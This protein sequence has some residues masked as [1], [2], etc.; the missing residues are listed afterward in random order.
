M[1]VQHQKDL[2][3]IAQILE[4][5]SKHMPRITSL[6]DLVVVSDRIQKAL[7]G[8]YR[9]L[10]QF[11]FQAI[12]YLKR[13]PIR[14]VF[15]ITWPCSRKPKFKDQF[16]SVS[17]SIREHT[18]WIDVEVSVGLHIKTHELTVH[19]RD[20]ILSRISL[21]ASPQTLP[22]PAAV[23]H[24][25]IPYVANPQFFSRTAELSRLSSLLIPNQA[26]LLIISIIGEGGIGKTQLALQFAYKHFADYTAI[27]WARADS[28]LSLAQSYENIAL[29]I[30]LTQ[31][32]RGSGSLDITR[33]HHSWLLVFDN[34]KSMDHLENY[35]PAG[36]HGSIIL[37]TRD[38][39]LTQP[40]ISNALR[41][42]CF[43]EEEG[44]QFI[45]EHFPSRPESSADRT[46]HARE[47][48][49]S[50]GG[51][52]LALSQVIRYASALHMPIGEVRTICSSPASFL[53]PN[54]ELS[55]LNRTDFY[56]PVGTSALW[57]QTIQSLGPACSTLA[58][59]LA[60]LNPDAIPG[61]LLGIK[62]SPRF[63]AQF[64]PAVAYV[65]DFKANLL[66]LL[67]HSLLSGGTAT[68][69]YKMHRL[70][71]AAI[72]RELTPE[73]TADAFALA[74]EIINAAF[75]EY[76]DNDRLVDSWQRCTEILP[77]VVRLSD[78]FSSSSPYTLHTYLQLGQLLER[79]AYYL[80][81]RS[82]WGDCGPL[83]E[84]ASTVTQ[85]GLQKA[86]SRVPPTDAGLIREFIKLVSDIENT[87]AKTKMQSGNFDQAL[88]L[89]LS[90]VTTRSTLNE[91]DNELIYIR[92]NVVYA[93]LCLG[94]PQEAIVMLAELGDLA[95]QQFAADRN[96][97]VYR[98][99]HAN[100]QGLLCFA[101]LI[102]GQFG[103]A[104][105]AAENCYQALSE[106]RKCQNDLDEAE[107]LILKA[108][109]M[110]TTA[111]G[112]SAET[113][114]TLHAYATVLKEKGAEE[115]Q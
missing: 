111:D 74:L 91:L 36:S 67:S 38:Q 89:Y 15:K 47:I 53:D 45:L 44:I 82:S 49:K 99:N 95:D 63:Q 23:Q 78:I 110:R 4:F 73:Q 70:I 7:C 106:I 20:E 108:L 8:L 102:L 93:Y 71:Q 56:H 100:T 34:V 58:R 29:E 21:L 24:R 98:N 75:P 103:E 96:L 35:W 46:E 16:A 2:E 105:A 41:L 31:S 97:L 79:A 39:R 28:T 83:L 115:A 13:N 88:Q 81:E 109:D 72:L 10:I 19:G 107:T 68:H 50:C 17:K 69:D 43:S 54:S 37:T 66:Q 42:R 33:E 62:S 87:L 30:G 112:S 61:D 55:T 12:M 52:P 32:S 51:L 101:H 27:F 65:Q 18:E 11:F 84:L 57:R 1:A 76:D 94:R 90:A 86:Q 3:S 22:S 60:H 64:G 25:M 113:A 104:R 77:H 14:N 5:V 48:C 40:P 92:R 85:A 59:F 9:D 114:V 80:I 6:I 26:G